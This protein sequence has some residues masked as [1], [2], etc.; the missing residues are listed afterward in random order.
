MKGTWS[1]AVSTQRCSALGVA[2]KVA[3]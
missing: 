3:S 2:E 1:A